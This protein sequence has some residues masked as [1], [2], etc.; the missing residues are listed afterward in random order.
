MSKRE[1]LA[2]VTDQTIDVFIQDSSS[3]VGAGLTGLV[4]DTASLVCYYRKGA[5][6][7][8][9]ALTLATQTV[10]GAHSDGG[11]VAVDGTNCPG[12]YR[13]DLSDTIVATAGMVTLYL[14]GATNMAPCL[15]EIEVVSVNKFDGVRG[16]MTA[17]PNA[18]ADAAGGLPISD[19][20][21]LDLDNRM[22][23]ATAITNLNTV[24][25]TDFAN[26]YDTTGDC[27]LARLDN[28]VTHGGNAAVLQLL[29]VN[30]TNSAGDAVS[31][32]ATGADGHGL[33][34]AGNGGG[35]GVHF[36][37][38]ATGHGLHTQGGSTSG[39]GIHTVAQTLGDGI[40]AIGAGGGFDVNA[41]IQGSLS[42]AVGS[43]TGA[44]G[45]V[46]GAVG[47]V[48]G[49]VGSVTGSVGSVAGHTPQTGDC[50]ARLTGTGAVTFASLTVTA[51]TTLSGAVSLGSTLGVTGT[52]TLAALTTTGTVTTNA[53]T[54]TNATTLSGAV[55][56]GSTLGITGA[57]TATNASN[58]LALGTFTVTTNAIAWNAAWD[59]EVQSECNDALVAYDA[60]TGTDV[61]AVSAP[62]A[63]TV[64]DAV[65]DEVQSGHTTAG[66]FGKYLDQQVSTITSSGGSGSVIVNEDYGGANNLRAVDSSGAGINGCT[67]KAFLTSDY[68]A[69]NTG[70][71]F[72]Q[73]QTTTNSNGDF[74]QPMNLDPAAY[75]LVYSLPESFQTTTKTLTVS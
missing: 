72:V 36:V 47:S 45:S 58:N 43:V 5:T 55:S 74:N 1:I 18:A 20:G 64:A 12:Q 70:A 59:T 46:T 9:T 41:D 7:T 44:V 24:F 40:E 63:A 32:N 8:P 50:F 73:A 71:A 28:S 6:G 17:L 19:A 42:G 34:V 49:A 52:T 65:W 13:L 57:I 27:F 26:V 16:G 38:G 3:T 39:D 67:I 2:G 30:V 35:D 60:A 15:V 69:G 31:L 22:P 75:T 37:G 10:G 56:L 29:S 4:F 66:T 14:R 51:G 62:S 53:L 21:G 11:F 23:H 68:S 33:Y 61:S 54:V 25:N 48:T